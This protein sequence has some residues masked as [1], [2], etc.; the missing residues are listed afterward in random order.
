MVAIEDLD[1]EEMLLR[2]ETIANSIQLLES[3]HSELV[4]TYQRKFEPDA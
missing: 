1:A 3:L 2:I 4:E